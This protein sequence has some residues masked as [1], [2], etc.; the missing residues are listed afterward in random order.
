MRRQFLHHRF[1]CD[2]L[3][4][5]WVRKM[6]DVMLSSTSAE[7]V[8][9]SEACKKAV[10]IRRFCKDLGLKLPSTLL[11]VDNTAAKA[12]AEHQFKLT[13]LVRHIALRHLYV[14]E[15]VRKRLVKLVWVPSAENPADL[16]TKAL[17]SVKFHSIVSL[18]YSYL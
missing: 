4:V 15:L 5:L 6:K 3:E 8:G 14:Q 16:G 9:M 12:I 17:D 13:E 11:H 10:M 2:V 18:V 1:G 7:L